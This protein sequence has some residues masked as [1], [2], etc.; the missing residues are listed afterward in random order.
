M[1][2]SSFPALHESELFD[3]LSGLCTRMVGELAAT[4]SMSALLVKISLPRYL[5][6]QHGMWHPGWLPVGHFDEG[7]QQWDG[8]HGC[9]SSCMLL[10]AIERMSRVHDLSDRVGVRTDLSRTLMRKGP[11]P[12]NLSRTASK[13]SA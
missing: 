10:Y 5:H 11:T 8:M 4:L 1:K 13:T 2:F 7:T 3:V 9:S 12:G 6:E